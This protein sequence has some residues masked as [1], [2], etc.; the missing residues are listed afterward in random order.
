VIQQ[1]PEAEVYGQFLQEC[2]ASGSVGPVPSE[3]PGP[4]KI[5]LYKDADSIDS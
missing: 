4:Y 5:V 1:G 3:D 2:D